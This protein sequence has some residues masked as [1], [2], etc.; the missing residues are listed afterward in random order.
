MYAD[1]QEYM[2]TY[3]QP[4]VLTP[5]C[6]QTALVQGIFTAS[7]NQSASVT[8]ALSAEAQSPQKSAQPSGDSA[9]KERFCQCLE[10][11]RRFCGRRNM[12]RCQRGETIAP[13]TKCNT[14]NDGDILSCWK[15]KANIWADNC[16]THTPQFILRIPKKTFLRQAVP[17]KSFFEIDCQELSFSAK[18]V[19]IGAVP[20][21]PTALVSYFTY[22][23]AAIHV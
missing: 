14:A 8:R 23:H 22:C 2:H 20:S 21:W 4:G 1:I 17:K 6:Q 10:F 11:C 3:I 13:R 18:M 19:K 12:Q 16:T 9:G 15:T 5:T 7:I